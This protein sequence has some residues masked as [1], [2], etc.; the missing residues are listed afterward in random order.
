MNRFKVT[1]SRWEPEKDSGQYSRDVRRAIA[2]VNSSSLAD[3]RYFSRAMA[4]TSSRASASAN[5]STLMSPTCTASSTSC[6]E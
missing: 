6:T 5:R 4:T 2:S 3:G 1:M